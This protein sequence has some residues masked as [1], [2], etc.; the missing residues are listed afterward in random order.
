MINMNTI[1][2]VS[3]IRA[4]NKMFFCVGNAHIIVEFIIFFSFNILKQIK[5][6]T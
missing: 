1:T 4:M 5:R 2:I 3:P 6:Q